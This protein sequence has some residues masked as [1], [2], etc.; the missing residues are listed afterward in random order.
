MDDTLVLWHVFLQEKGVMI[1][2]QVFSSDSKNGNG[3][4]LGLY[5]NMCTYL[6]HRQIVLKEQFLN[7]WHVDF[8]TRV[9]YMKKVL[10]SSIFK[11]Q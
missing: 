1:I 10:W 5:S 8:R 7:G 3:C 9:S 6:T 4:I 2:D 11:W